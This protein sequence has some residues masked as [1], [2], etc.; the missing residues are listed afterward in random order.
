VVFFDL[1]PGLYRQLG[2]EEAFFIKY[3]ALYQEG[4]QASVLSFYIYSYPIFVL[5][6]QT[7]Y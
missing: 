1:E 4:F 3:V 5:S 7:C 2:T 6:S